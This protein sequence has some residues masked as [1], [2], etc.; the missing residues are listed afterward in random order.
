[1]GATFLTAKE[2]TTRITVWNSSKK[3]EWTNRR[4]GC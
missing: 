2:S 4:C 3:G 1:L